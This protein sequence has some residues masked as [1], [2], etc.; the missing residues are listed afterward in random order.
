[1]FLLPERNVP[2]P[3]SHDEVCKTGRLGRGCCKAMLQSSP[4]R[5]HGKERTAWGRRWEKGGLPYTHT[6]PGCCWGMGRRKVL[7][8][9]SWNKTVCCPFRLQPFLLSQIRRALEQT[10]GFHRQSSTIYKMEKKP[11]T[12]HFDQECWVEGEK[13]YVKKIGRSKLFVQALC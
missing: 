5:W 1:M 12:S 8:V 4:G 7:P 2:I 9:C 3:L 11:K 13:I 6:A 10:E